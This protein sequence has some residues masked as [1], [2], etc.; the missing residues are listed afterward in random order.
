MSYKQSFKDGFGPHSV[1]VQ[2]KVTN[3]LVETY[4]FS[5]EQLP[6]DCN[7]VLVAS[8]S[9]SVTHPY[10]EGGT[11]YPLVLSEFFTLTP[12]DGCTLTCNYGDTC[13][14]ATALTY[15]TAAPTA[16]FTEPA[17]LTWDSG[18]GSAHPFDG[19]SSLNNV[20]EGYGP[21]SVCLYCTSNNAATN[22]PFQKS[23]DITQTPVDCAPLLTAKAT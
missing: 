9:T 20:V 6:L 4:T 12:T 15:Q 17:T 19:F 1:C 2:C 16:I 7:S 18:S 14:A 8:T 21:H 23:L 22:S 3:D 11:G 5:I 10:V 13:G